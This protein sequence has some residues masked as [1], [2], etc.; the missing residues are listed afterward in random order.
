M[1]FSKNLISRNHTGISMRPVQDHRS[2]S[3]RRSEFGI[4]AEKSKSDRQTSK[5]MQIFKNPKPRP[6]SPCTTRPCC[7][8][9][10]VPRISGAM[11]ASKIDSLLSELATDKTIS[12]S[13]GWIQRKSRKTDR[14]AHVAQTGHFC[15]T[16]PAEKSIAWIQ[17]GKGYTASTNQI[18]P[19]Q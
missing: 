1:K 12:K 6:K 8:S 3:V 16:S 17:R 10:F 7:C 5:R 2:R 18:Y 4:A 11:S 14:N 9:N 15:K 19:T 13:V